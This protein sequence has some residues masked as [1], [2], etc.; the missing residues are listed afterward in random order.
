MFRERSSTPAKPKSFFFTALATLTAVN[1]EI[2]Y[3]S[4]PS[5]S[6]KLGL[7]RAPP[8]G[9]ILLAAANL[10]LI[11][12]L[13]FYG[14]DPTDQWQR[15]K[16][17][18]RTG[19]I[20]MCQLPLLFLLSGRQNIIGALTG[21]GYERL[22]WL[23]RWAARCLLLTATIHMG[24]WFADWAPYGY[25]AVKVT[26]DPMTKQGLIAWAVLVWIV[27]S[28]MTPIRGWNYEF[29]IVQHL[30]SFVAFMTMVY[31]HTP[32]EVHVWI[33]VPVGLFFLDRLVRLF[34][35]LHN[36][37]AIFHPR[38]RAGNVWACKATFAPLS[39]DTSRIT[40]Q[41]PPL[42]WRAG[43]H[44]F[45]TC[46]S[47]VPLQSHPFTVA[48]LPRD[49]KMELIVQSKKGGTRRFLTHAKRHSTALPSSNVDVN[50]ASG[51][52]VA[53]EGPYGRM[54]PL[55]QFD[56][57]IFLAGSTGATFTVPLM[58]EIISAWTET[59]QSRKLFGW[60]R[61]A[62]RHIRFVWVVKSSGQLSWFSEQLSAAASDLKC[63]KESR[64]GPWAG[65]VQVEMSVYLTCD[66]SFTADK[67]T[68]P[69][70]PLAPSGAVRSKLNHETAV[71]SPSALAS[72]EIVP[73]TGKG[74]ASSVHSVALLS[75]DGTDVRGT[76]GPD[77]TCCCTSTIDDED[78]VSGS[79]CT[80]NCTPPEPLPLSQAV[81]PATT[82]SLPYN[83][84][85][86]SPGPL[87][88]SITMLSGRPNLSAIVRKTLEQAL[89]ES[90]VVACGP[91]GLV[92][93]VRR[94]VAGLSDERAVHK[95]TG[96]Q[97]IYLHT[98]AFGY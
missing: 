39:H 32:A 15:E 96:A 47:I 26:T 58:R 44:V 7:F 6:Y 84:P 50:M 10:V 36:S 67:P 29:F 3:A 61:P 80:C 54:R 24:Y 95:G 41:D 31:L 63:W 85:T 72:N 13:C 74:V 2:A 17:G 14:L 77:G 52:S 42:K 93:D 97:G 25:I 49:G 45:I 40:I 59:R 76:C 48:S 56:S 60:L 55:S 12:V 90:A 65:E 62:T 98:E 34:S 71:E 21:F 28:S 27:V 78:A 66:L 30:V 5:C 88:S 8:L 19:F 18:Y 91:R 23:H 89:G 68:S 37:L 38:N 35:V 46:P 33:W 70:T 16:V 43:Q 22:N 75:T 53:I 11:L 87:H 20:T 9:S 64:V 79:A 4:L 94:V 69:S 51:T 83:S 73:R 57:V 92:D 1:R 82:K 81:S 86:P